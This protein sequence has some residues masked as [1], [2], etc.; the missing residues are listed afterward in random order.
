M[1]EMLWLR[2]LDYEIGVLTISGEKFEEKKEGD[3]RLY[4]FVEKSFGSD[5]VNVVRPAAS[6]WRPAACSSHRKNYSAFTF[7]ETARR[8]SR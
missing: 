2:Q 5:R 8:V 3:I 6:N 1:S 7:I 4:H